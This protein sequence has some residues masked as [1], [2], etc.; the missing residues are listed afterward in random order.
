M[1]KGFYF[2][3]SYCISAWIS[4]LSKIAQDFRRNLGSLKKF[5]EIIHQYNFWKHQLKF[6]KVNSLHISN[7][8]CVRPQLNVDITKIA[9][10]F[11]SALHA[12]FPKNYRKLFT[13]IIS[14]N[15]LGKA[16]IEIIGNKPVTRSSHIMNLDPGE[17]LRFINRFFSCG[18]VLRLRP[19]STDRA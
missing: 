8:G 3:D 15:F 16:A 14:E 2:A 12:A 19:C 17:Y 13:D 7:F 11:Y 4:F 1:K 18:K 6:V 9:G 10:E 5:L